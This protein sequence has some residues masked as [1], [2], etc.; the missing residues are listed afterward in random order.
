MEL[1]TYLD[2][3]RRRWWVIATLV[4]LTLALSLLLSR[5]WQPRPAA[6][7]LGMSFSVGVQ[8][9]EIEDVY[10]Y[11]GY[12]T[13]LSSEYL[14]DDFS[15]IVKGSEFAAAV[16]QRL[17]GQGIDLPAGTIQGSAQ[18]GTVHRI[19]Q[20][21]VH[22]GDPAQLPLI[23]DAVEATLV[24]D[25]DLFMPRLLADQGAVYRIHRGAVAAI[26]PGLRERLDLPLKLA[27]AFLAGVGLVFLLDYLDIRI[28]TSKQL[29]ALGFNV[30]A[31]IPRK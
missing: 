24:E 3:V 20:V 14:I 12:Y 13:A 10:T 30:L 7:V 2:I 4:F 19:L 26:G 22:G 1:R 27:L 16:S 9:Q 11:D 28:R 29:E 21:A 23:A 15:E 18:T 6:Y 31:E 17:A 25:A 5:P 8:P